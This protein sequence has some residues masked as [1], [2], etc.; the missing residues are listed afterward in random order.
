M[1]MHDLYFSYV[2]MCSVHPGVYKILYVCA[3]IQNDLFSYF[4]E[5]ACGTQHNL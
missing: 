3:S 2:R 1:V 5:L 4:G